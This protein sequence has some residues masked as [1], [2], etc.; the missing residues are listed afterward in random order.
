MVE[1]RLPRNG[2]AGAG[3]FRGLGAAALAEVAAAAERVTRAAGERFFRQG[4]EAR[5]LYVVAAGEVK[6]SQVTPEGQGVVLRYVGAGEMFGCVPLYGGKVYPAA[7]EAVTDA[8]ALAWDRPAADRLM[9]R[10]PRVAINALE[11]LGEELAAL[12]ARYQE[13]ATERVEQRVARALLRLVERGG[14]KVAGGVQI[15]F[16][17]SRQDLAEWTGTTLHTVSRVLSAWQERG[18][19]VSGRRRVVVR[20]PAALARLADEIRACLS[21]RKEGPAA[22]A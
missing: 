2:L 20:D 9:E 12:R 17:L 14:R 10:Y 15:G 7:A 5:R 13:L 19:I 11:L 22:P 21:Q 18:W 6:I 4:Q 16:P 8:A 3:I 1:P